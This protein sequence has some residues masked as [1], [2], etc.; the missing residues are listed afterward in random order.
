[1]ATNP[2][3]L[4]L[5]TVLA[6]PVLCAAVGAGGCG[7]IDGLADRTGDAIPERLRGLELGYDITKLFG[8]DERLAL[9]P[10]AVDPA[11]GAERVTLTAWWQTPDGQ[12]HSENL[13]AAEAFADAARFAGAVW[14]KVTPVGATPEEVSA[15]TPLGSG[16]PRSGP[17]RVVE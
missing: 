7:D 17:E 13:P 9:P 12:I 2:R 8:P 15:A 4:L 16:W 11:W 14:V 3:P 10:P 6:A 1:M 5:R